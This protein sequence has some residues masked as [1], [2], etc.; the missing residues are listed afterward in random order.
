[1][2]KL[3]LLMDRRVAT[4][5]QGIDWALAEAMAIGSILKTG[6]SV[7]LCGQDAERGS[8][9]QRHLAVVDPANDAKHVITSYS[10]HY[11]KLYELRLACT[12]P[13][14]AL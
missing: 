5:D 9:S 6:T 1:M 7:R 11:T 12:S 8:F 14:V 13:K 4:I 2:P 3:K 10:I